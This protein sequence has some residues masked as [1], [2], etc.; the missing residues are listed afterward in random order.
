[1]IWCW[2][3]QADKAEEV[4]LLNYNP[5][6]LTEGSLL[7]GVQWCFTPLLRLSMNESRLKKQLALIP[8]NLMS[9]E[10]LSCV[11]AAITCSL[12]A[13]SSTRSTRAC[14]LPNKLGL[15]LQG[16]LHRDA[17]LNHVDA[18]KMTPWVISSNL[19]ILKERHGG[20]VHLRKHSA[21]IYYYEQTP[22]DNNYYFLFLLLWQSKTLQ[23]K[24]LFGLKSLQAKHKA[25]DSRW[26][27]WR[28]QSCLRNEINK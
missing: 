5:S 14:V 11:W 21:F 25:R 9:T 13:Q 6:P 28:C 24:P 17:S 4:P 10:S 26:K 8:L 16:V 1:M 7:Q 15:C 23:N 19:I 20:F 27:W 22:A 12:E 3:V 2:L 18:Q